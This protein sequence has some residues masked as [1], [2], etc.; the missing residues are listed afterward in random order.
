MG[1]ISSVNFNTSMMATAA[2]LA[3]TSSKADELQTRLATASAAGA[4]DDELM[5]ACKGFETYLVEQVIKQVK[6]SL[7][8]SEEEEND[9]TAYF[10]DMLYGKYAEQ[11][12]EKGEL[13]IAQ[14]LYDA[15]KRDYNIGTKSQE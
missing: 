4:S 6:E 10:G 5:E 11:I 2:E 1:D 14:Q 9:Y 12:T 15:M 8:K 7:A 13:G 3:K